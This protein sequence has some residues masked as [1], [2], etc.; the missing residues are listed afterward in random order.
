MWAGAV[1]ILGMLAG[2]AP[3]VPPP[4]PLPTRSFTLDNGLRVAVQEDHRAPLVAVEL[5]FGVGSSADGASPGLAHL[6][7]HLC[8]EGSPNAPDGAFDRWLEGAGGESDGATG[9]DTL[10]LHAVAPVEALELL[11]FLESDRMLALRFDA[12]DL[13]NQRAI[14][15][16]ELAGTAEAAGGRLA[17][18]RA[19]V[20]FGA[21]DPYRLPPAGQ[22]AALAELS[23]EQVLA[24]HQ[25]WMGP[26]N[27]ALAL[28][29][30]LDLDE[31]EMLVR[32]WFSEIPARPAPPPA[33]QPDVVAGGGVWVWP[34]DVYAPSLSLL[35]PTV[36]A[37]HNH[38]PAFDLLA[39]I[40]ADGDAWTRAS[41]PRL[42]A[43]AAAENLRWAGTL[44]VELRP[45]GGVAAGRVTRAPFERGRR[46]V[47]RALARIA[48][49]GPTTAELDR[50]KRR[51][52]SA[53][54]RATESMQAR[55]GALGT[56]LLW[57]GRTDCLAA[58]L[59][60]RLA[61]QPQDVALAAAALGSPAL[62]YMVPSSRVSDFATSDDFIL[63]LE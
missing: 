61:V 15:A 63:D 25:R 38:E 6:V 44:R 18:A 56:C 54:L 53:S 31:A 8:F 57:T 32:R 51:Y 7:E 1:W 62:L 17:E 46:A 43:R 22:R 10:R 2:G 50:A 52:A 47:E 9:R 34:T 45:A 36:P 55:A 14:V 33:L 60:A 4:S 26:G 19:R 16:Q 23:L 37:G 35:W 11:L 28:V 39:E 29:G 21:E 30:D 3:T 20:R 59:S 42:E 49:R 40:L 12:E 58:E 27:A 24:F 5:V 41:Q 13:E 48:A